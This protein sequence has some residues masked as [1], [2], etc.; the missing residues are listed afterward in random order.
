MESTRRSF[1]AGASAAALLGI[2]APIRAIVPD[3]YQ[4]LMRRVM[5]L[6]WYGQGMIRSDQFVGGQFIS[7]IGMKFNLNSDWS[8]DGIM[9]ETIRIENSKYEAQSTIWGDCWVIADKA[10]L[11]ISKMRLDEGSRLPQ[12]YTWGSSKGEFRFYN[13]SER[14]GRFALSGKLR[15]VQDGTI[16]EVQLNDM[17]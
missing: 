15:D 17:D 4:T 8:F 12:P 16:I 7:T 3:R 10:G 9:L 2:A 13:D 14:P 1:I 11:T 5:G 6:G